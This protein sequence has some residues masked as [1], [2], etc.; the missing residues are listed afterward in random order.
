MRAAIL[1]V[2]VLF[3]AMPA[4]AWLAERR[5]G[6][7]S[8][9]CLIRRVETMR[10]QTDDPEIKESCRK[11]L[12]LLDAL[13]AWRGKVRPEDEIILD[14]KDEQRLILQAMG[15]A[16]VKEARAGFWNE[17][18]ASTKRWAWRKVKTAI[19]NWTPW[20][21]ILTFVYFKLRRRTAEVIG[22]NSDTEGVPKAMRKRIFTSPVVQRAH[23]RLKGGSTTTS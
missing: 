15:L 12:Y 11:S 10:D 20:L 13:Y 21:A 18:W 2:A 1:M 16:G 23:A 22:Y 5:L 19:W 3:T 4:Q 9:N 7:H 6:R 14:S 17:A 8:L